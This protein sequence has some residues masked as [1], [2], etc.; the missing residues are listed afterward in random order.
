MF[1]KFAT[2]FLGLSAL[3]I[4][5]GSKID[6]QKT[7]KAGKYGS[8]L[9]EFYEKVPWEEYDKFFCSEDKKTCFSVSYYSFDS[10]IVVNL[11]EGKYLFS[12]Y[13]VAQRLGAIKLIDY[14]G[15]FELN[16]VNEEKF[17]IEAITE[18][19]IVWKNKKGESIF[20]NLDSPDRLPASLHR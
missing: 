18:T 15:D 17:E 12:F 2:I 4:F 7:A 8:P 14:S 5:G 1:V 19:R 16:N 20:Y 9:A 6:I 10:I 13:K 3:I 11:D